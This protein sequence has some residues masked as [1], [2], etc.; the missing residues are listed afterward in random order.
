ML[1]KRKIYDYNLNNIKIFLNHRLDYNLKNIK[2]FQNH[3]FSIQNYRGNKRH[4][5][6]INFVYKVFKPRDLRK[7]IFLI[8]LNKKNNKIIHKFL[9]MSGILP[10]AQIKKDI[11]IIFW[12]KLQQNLKWNKIY[13]ERQF[14]VWQKEILIKV[15]NKK[16]QVNNLK[17]R[18]FYIN[19]PKEKIQVKRKYFYILIF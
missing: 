5:N 17:N 13:K 6:S 11:L 10:K 9:I 19:L 3:R 8:Y 4:R 14:N 18:L 16:N 15:L 1:K 12:A 7:I 2:I